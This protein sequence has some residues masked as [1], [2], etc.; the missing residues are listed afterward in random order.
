MKFH[1]TSAS[2][3]QQIQQIQALI[4]PILGALE[5]IKALQTKQATQ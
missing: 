4:Q 5:Q 3:A 1:H 2:K